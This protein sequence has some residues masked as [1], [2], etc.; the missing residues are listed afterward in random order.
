MAKS[1]VVT[2]VNLRERLIREVRHYQINSDVKPRFSMEQLVYI[3]MF[4]KRRPP[5][6]EEIFKRILEQFPYFRN[7]IASEVVQST[8]WWN[9]QFQEEYRKPKKAPQMLHEINAIIHQVEPASDRMVIADHQMMVH[10]EQ[11]DFVALLH[12]AVGGSG[13]K[14]ETKANFFCLPAELRTTIYDMVFGYPGHGLFVHAFDFTNRKER[15]FQVVEDGCDPKT[16]T[17]GA[18]GRHRILTRPMVTILAPLLT[19]RQFY[20]EAMS[21]FYRT[22]HFYM[23]NMKTLQKFLSSIPTNRLRHFTNISVVYDTDERAYGPRG[24]RLLTDIEHLQ[25]LHIH[26]DEK[27]WLN[28]SLPYGGTWSGTDEERRRALCRIPGMAGLRAL[29][30]LEEVS[31]TGEC[32][33]LEEIVKE[34]IFEPKTAIFGPKKSANGAK[35]KEAVV[36][37]GAP[38]PKK[39]KNEKAA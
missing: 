31:L 14:N 36:A 22:N 11:T 19:C 38:G 7:L 39:G 10:L 17:D 35:R 12:E 20:T 23:H 24:V 18:Y 28:R 2:S 26:I 9:N 1:G 21:A 15:R 4:Y 27:K 8:Q 29:R 6:V 5:T 3:A 33:M 30:G 13:L 16:A 37:E 32:P 34:H 25:K